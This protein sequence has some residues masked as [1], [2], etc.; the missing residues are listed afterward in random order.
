MK[1]T[2]IEEIE[3]MLEEIPDDA[4]FNSDIEDFSDDDEFD[5]L[6]NATEK[7][8]ALHNA[9]EEEFDA[10][11]NATEEFEPLQNASSFVDFDIE[12]MGMLSSIKLV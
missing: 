11:H 10:L 12:N 9:T 4:A 1:P 6:H 2:T 8:D 5:A 7:F 3:C